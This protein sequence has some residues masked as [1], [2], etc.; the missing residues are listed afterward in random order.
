MGGA[1]GRAGDAWTDGKRPGSSSSCTASCSQLL[2][3]SLPRWA[4]VGDMGSDEDKKAAA[5]LA[6]LVSK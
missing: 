1:S 6:G 5:A 3:S 2:R 4:G